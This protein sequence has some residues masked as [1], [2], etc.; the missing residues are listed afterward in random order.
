MDKDILLQKIKDKKYN[1]EQ[2]LSWVT[3]LPANP[4]K[5]KPIEY[6]AGDV[7]MHGVFKHPYI[8]LKKRKTDWVC[9]LLTSEENCPEILEVCQSRFFSTN[10]ITKALFTTTEIQGSFINVYGNDS[11]L[12]KVLIKLKENLK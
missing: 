8:L 5:R 11:H 3:V 1:H 2:L 9:G 6:K 12:K 10:Y 7:L 4:E